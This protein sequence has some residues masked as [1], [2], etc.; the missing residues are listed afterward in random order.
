MKQFIKYAMILLKLSLFILVVHSVDATAEI[1]VIANK[2]APIENISKGDLKSIYTGKLFTFPNSNQEV[3]PLDL[4]GEGTGKENFY[5]AVTGKSLRKIK[6]YWARQLFTGKGKPPE[7]QIDEE[8]MKKTVNSGIAYIGYIS[9]ENLDDT[10][11]VIF[12]IA[13]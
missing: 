8:T 12:R 7:S 1:L 2:N 6:T 11:K 13:N 9:A 10:V 5:K 3:K 4:T